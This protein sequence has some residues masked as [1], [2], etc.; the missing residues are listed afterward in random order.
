M[1]LIRLSRPARWP[2]WSLGIVLLMVIE[3]WRRSHFFFLG[4]HDAQ[5]SGEADLLLSFSVEE[6]RSAPFCSALPHINLPTIVLTG[7]P[8]LTAHQCTHLA[9]FTTIV[10]C[11]SFRTATTFLNVLT[12]STTTSWAS[13]L[14]FFH[15]VSFRRLLFGIKRGWVGCEGRTHEYIY[16]YLYLLFE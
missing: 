15:E 10:R 14:Y 7:A 9:M 13:G 5:V 16:I 12:D 1:E 4:V 6:R 8:K 2:F 11:E 3:S